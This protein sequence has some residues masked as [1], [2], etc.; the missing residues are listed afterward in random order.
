VAREAVEPQDADALRAAAHG[1]AAGLEEPTPPEEGFGHASVAEVVPDEPRVREEDDSFVPP[2]PV[3]PEVHRP[4]ATSRTEVEA[5]PFAAAELA[6]SAGPR[7]AAEGQSAATMGRRRAHSLFAKVTGA[8][9]AIHDAA[10]GAETRI[11]SDDTTRIMPTMAASDGEPAAALSPRVR[12][13]VAAQPSLQTEDQ[14]RLAGLDAADKGDG[15]QGE[16][17]LLDIPAFLR[18]Q[19]N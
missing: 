11:G 13:D 6:N 8:A 10:Q 17:D 7:R 3:E 2:L 14:P 5:D 1:E 18:R 19:A 16:E 9:R 15:A 12:H 4:V